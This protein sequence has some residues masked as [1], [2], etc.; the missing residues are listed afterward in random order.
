V[1]RH[2]VARLP[3]RLRRPGAGG[4]GRGS[5]LRPLLLAIF[6]LAGAVAVA[7]LRHRLY[8]IDVVIR[9]S[10]IYAVLTA[11]LAATYLV[12]V[13]VLGVL[14]PARSDL[15]VALSTLAAAAAIRP[16]RRRIQSAVDRRF[17]R[18]RYDAERTLVS[19]GARLR[20]EL[21]LDAVSAELQAVAAETMQPS[22]VSLWLRRAP[23]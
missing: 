11:T 18:R 15:A 7:I 19:F 20:D 22:H 4:R 14:L 1:G 8:D 23:R 3:P 6:L 17:Y 21:E 16:V 5:R 12:S 10:L 13:L 2:G 9:R